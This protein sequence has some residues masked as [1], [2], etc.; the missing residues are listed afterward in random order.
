MSLYSLLRAILLILLNA[1]ILVECFSTTPL[2]INRIKS[3][4]TD[5]EHDVSKIRD[6]TTAPIE[7]MVSNNDD[8]IITYATDFISNSEPMS[9]TTYSKITRDRH[10]D[11]INLFDAYNTTIIR[12]E[13]IDKSTLNIRWDASWIPAGS[14]WLYDLANLA[15]WNVTRKSLDPTKIAKFSG[16]KRIIELFRKAFATG[17]ITLPISLVEGNTI[18]SIKD[19]SISLKENIDLVSEA[20]KCRIQ[21]RRVAQELAEWLDVSRRPPNI[22]YDEWASIVRERILS[23]VPGTGALDIDPNEDE[24]E[25]AVVLAFFSVIVLGTS[26]EFANYLLNY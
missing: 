1:T 9:I 8:T 2:D 18:V 16:Y 24:N 5:G 19:N 14:T 22:D 10:T 11:C 4:I 6:A 3:V 21:N 23:G 7:K 26:F 25:G 17:N 15:G 20:D 12:C 13:S